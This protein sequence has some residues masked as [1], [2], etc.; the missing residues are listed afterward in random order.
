MYGENSI[1]PRHESCHTCNRDGIYYERW[2]EHSTNHDSR[3]AV[4][5]L[6]IEGMSFNWEFRMEIMFVGLGVPYSVGDPGGN[7]HLD[8]GSSVWEQ[9]WRGENKLPS[10]LET[11]QELRSQKAWQGA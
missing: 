4:N 6:E 8:L 11:S 5:C 2:N 10:A 9:E 1:L 3:L 7:L